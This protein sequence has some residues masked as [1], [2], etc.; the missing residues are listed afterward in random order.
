[1][2]DKTIFEFNQPFAGTGFILI[3]LTNQANNIVLME[4]IVQFVRKSEGIL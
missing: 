4:N 2:N 1:M 3:N